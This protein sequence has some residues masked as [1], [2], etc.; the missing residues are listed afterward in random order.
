MITYKMAILKT[1][2]PVACGVNF[3]A[4]VLG[5]RSIAVFQS[6][7]VTPQIP[8]P[9]VNAMHRTM[10]ANAMSLKEASR[11]GSKNW[12]MPC[13]A[14]TFNPVRGSSSS[15]KT[16]RARDLFA[17]N[18]TPFCDTRQNRQLG[19]RSAVVQAFHLRSSWVHHFRL[20]GTCLVNVHTEVPPHIG[21]LISG[22]DSCLV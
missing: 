15:G 14:N 3:S 13:I 19:C 6:L 7:P 18:T 5:G 12:G 1:R 8:S 4:A 21:I 16:P 11:G 22:H 10:T 9:V 20:N 2:F 17:A